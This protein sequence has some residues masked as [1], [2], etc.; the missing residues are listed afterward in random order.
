[1]AKRSSRLETLRQGDAEQGAELVNQ[2]ATIPATLS[3]K[4]QTGIL[5]GE[6]GFKGLIVSDAMSMSGL[7]IY[8]SQEEAGVR[9]FLAGTDILEKPADVDAMIRGLVAAVKS[10]RIPMQTLDDSVRRQIAWKHELGLF[11]NR[12]TLIDQMDTLV[13]GAESTDFDR[14]DRDQSDHACSK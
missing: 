9:A 14:R 13:A 5:R 2:K 12:L 7:T 10:G 4:V 8:F 1:M 11:K 3:E 6:M